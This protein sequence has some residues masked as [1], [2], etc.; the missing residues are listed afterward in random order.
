[1]NMLL[2]E[3]M[4]GVTPSAT[5]E[6]F[7][8]ADDMVLA[9]DVSA[10]QDATVANYA[11]VQ[12]GAKS[13]TASLNP[14]TKQSAYI[15]A[16][17]STTKTGNQ[18][19]IAFE[20]DRY[21]GDEFQDYADSIKYAT[22]QAAIVNYVYFNMLTGKGEKGT[23]TL[24]LSTDGSGNAEENLAVSGTLEKSGA[25]PEAYTWS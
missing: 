15:R 20:V 11:V 12:M 19:T 5:F 18:R 4:T 6:G 16:G 24:S 13:V 8:T 21:C 9:V 17:K 14:E 22:G 3:L 1:M 10:A 23:A 7:V 2:S 25:A